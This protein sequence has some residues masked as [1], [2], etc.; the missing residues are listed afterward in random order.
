[1]R[2]QVHQYFWVSERRVP[3]YNPEVSEEA[4]LHLFRHDGL[5]IK[6]SNGKLLDIFT[7][8]EYIQKV[9]QGELM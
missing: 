2:E 1:M 4:T 8:Q 6:S 3:V 9:A 5:Y 7:Y